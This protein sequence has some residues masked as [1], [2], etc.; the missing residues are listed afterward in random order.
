MGTPVKWA[1]LPLAQGVLSLQQ[2]G[3]E[4]QP[5]TSDESFPEDVVGENVPEL[6]VPGERGCVEL[7]TEARPRRRPAKPRRTPTEA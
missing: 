3:Q 2:G 4:L 6:P 7:E 5:G 1:R